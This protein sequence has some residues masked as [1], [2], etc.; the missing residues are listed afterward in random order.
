MALNMYFISDHVPGEAVW[1]IGGKNHRIKKQE[2]IQLWQ[3]V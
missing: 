1:D 3:L 2:F